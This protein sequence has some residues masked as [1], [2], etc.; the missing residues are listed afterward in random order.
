MNKRK[1]SYSINI[2]NKKVKYIKK[3][4]NIIVIQSFIRKILSIQKYNMLIDNIYQKVPKNIKYQ[5]ETTLLGETIKN[6]NK[7]YVYNYKEKDNYFFFDIRELY[8]HIKNTTTNPYTNNQI[9]ERYI[10]QIYRIFN[11]LKD[12]GIKIRI[13]NRIP[14]ISRAN[15]Y[16]TDFIQKL[17]NYNIYTTVEQFNNLD[18]IDYL[19]IISTLIIYY[20]SDYISSEIYTYFYNSTHINCKLYTIDVIE[21]IIYNNT[22]NTETIYMYVGDLI[23]TLTNE[24]E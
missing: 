12:D 8:K 19:Y 9:P 24:D 2:A 20:E 21:N 3:Y 4:Y 1:I 23:D 11:K 5:N 22:N 14:V 7:L 17:N 10:K 6:I 16:I 15:V 18:L 13:S